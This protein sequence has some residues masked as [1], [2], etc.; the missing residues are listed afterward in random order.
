MC[1]IIESFLTS[2][3]NWAKRC[4]SVEHLLQM[5]IIFKFFGFRVS[6]NLINL[7]NYLISL[8]NFGTLAKTVVF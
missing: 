3:S 5:D 1:F 6:L 4:C 7:Y 2:E 8:Q